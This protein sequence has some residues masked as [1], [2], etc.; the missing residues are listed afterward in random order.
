MSAL[1]MFSIPVSEEI[2]RLE[3]RL[4]RKAAEK[5][6]HRLYN[7]CLFWEKYSEKDVV[8][9][10]FTELIKDETL[11]LKLADSGSYENWQKT[12]FNPPEFFVCL[13]CGECCFMTYQS[14]DKELRP[15]CIDIF[16]PRQIIE[17]QFVPA[18]CGVHDIEILLGFKNFYEIGAIDIKI[19]DKIYKEIPMEEAIKFVGGR[20]VWEAVKFRFK[21]CADYCFHAALFGPCIKGI[22]TWEMEKNQCPDVLLP[23][24]VEKQLEIVRIYRNR[25]EELLEEFLTEEKSKIKTR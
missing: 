8:I 5:V 23:K 9:K 25:L 4:A 19:K 15:H 16:K 20:D 11:Y 7:N 17:N 1:E 22:K 14:P 2:L 12:E 6:F 3:R 24:G 18:S 13:R 10:K 21:I